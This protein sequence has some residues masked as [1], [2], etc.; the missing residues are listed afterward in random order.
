[1]STSAL[2]ILHVVLGSEPGG[3]SRYVV[4]LTRAMREQGHDV[5]VA[6]D[7]GEAHGMFERQRINWIDIPLKGGPLAF[8]KSASLLKRHLRDHPVD[9]IHTH[10]RRATLLARRVQRHAAAQSPDPSRSKV[11]ILYTL[12]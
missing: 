5:T 12:H 3:L 2:R 11:P 10:Y 6:G 8:L 4:E 9:V 1:M 7:R